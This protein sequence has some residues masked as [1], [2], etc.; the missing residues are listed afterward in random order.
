MH[1]MTVLKSFK[2]FPGNGIPMGVMA[3]EAVA[4]R[5]HFYWGEV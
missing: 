3:A 2:L 4:Q 1:S 5:L